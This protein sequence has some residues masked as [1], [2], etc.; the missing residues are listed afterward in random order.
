MGYLRFIL[1][2]TVLM[3]HAGKVF[4]L[5]YIYPWHMPVMMFFVISGFYMQ[6]IASKYKER[7][8]SD[9]YISRI[10]R[11][12]PIYYFILLA[13]LS[14]PF[15][16]NLSIN[17]FDLTKSWVNYF[18]QLTL[19]AKSFLIFVNLAIVGQEWTLIFSI[20]DFGDKFIWDPMQGVQLWTFL[21]VGQAWSLSIELLFYLL[22]PLLWKMG[23]KSLGGVLFSIMLLHLIVTY[24]FPEIYSSGPHRFFPTALRF[25]ILGMFSQRICAYLCKKKISKIHLR[26]FLYIALFI[27]IA[28]IPISYE[29]SVWLS[30]FMLPILFI[31]FKESDLDKKF[32]ELSYPLYMSHIFIFS[33]IKSVPSI[34]HQGTVTFIITL[35]ISYLLSRYLVTYFDRLRV[36]FGS[37]RV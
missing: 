21:P 36:R 2:V 7:K 17:Q 23:D 24:F 9:F 22:V 35:A 37:G 26:K 12:Y 20:G 5:K 29:L 10:L 19:L 8:V 32:G 3:N 11:I 31:V 14:A 1:A 15:I 13:S 4:G 6:L 28:S 27:H 30:I 16:F 25:F 34:K 18:N 33:I